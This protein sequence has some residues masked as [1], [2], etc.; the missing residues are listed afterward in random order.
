MDLFLMTSFH[1]QDAETSIY[2][3]FSGKLVKCGITHSGEVW[4]SHYSKKII[5]FK[6]PQLEPSRAEAGHHSG[7]WPSSGV[8]KA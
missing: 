6:R 5:W 2:D 1:M 7:L 3:L 4:N 8:V